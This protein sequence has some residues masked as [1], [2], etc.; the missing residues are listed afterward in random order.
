MEHLDKLLDEYLDHCLGEHLDEYLPDIK[1]M[2]P[3]VLVLQHPRRRSGPC[4]SPPYRP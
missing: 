4:L 1:T 2:V 3:R